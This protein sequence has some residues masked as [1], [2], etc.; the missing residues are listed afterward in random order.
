MEQIHNAAVLQRT[1][2]SKHHL[3]AAQHFAR[4]ARD[5]EDDHNDPPRFDPRHRAYVTNAVLAA[6]AFLEAAVN[7]V[8]DDVADSHPGYV[9]PLPAECQRRMRD[10]WDDQMERQPVLEKYRVALLCA[11]CTSFNK[12]GPPYQDADLLTK[13][14][15]RLVHARAETQPTDK[16]KLMDTLK[17]KFNPSR[18][19]QNA[20]NPYW[21]DQCLGAGCAV[22]AV[23]SATV[24]ADEFF[25]R[26]K[27]SPNYKR[28]DDFPA[29]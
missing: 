7:E 13:L 21:P 16:D 24:F 28:P 19:M 6:V 9:D 2:S 12:G 25:S 3:W 10:L 17:S 27:L 26:M 20:A 18:L 29:P 11:W 14:R 23:R 5:I 1:Y 22:W 15:N 4:L 8:F